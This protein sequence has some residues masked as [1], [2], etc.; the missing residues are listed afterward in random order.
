MTEISSGTGELEPDPHVECKKCGPHCLWWERS[1][2]APTGLMDLIDRQ[3]VGLTSGHWTWKS[4]IGLAAMTLIVVGF[5]IAVVTVI[6]YFLGSVAAALAGLVSVAAVINFFRRN[7]QALPSNPRP[8]AGPEDP[9]TRRHD[10]GKARAVRLS[11]FD[12]LLLD[13]PTNDLELDDLASCSGVWG[14][15]D[16]LGMPELRQRGDPDLT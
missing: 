6:G 1:R 10:R 3:M 16:G 11:R 4:M 14:Q 7:R 8:A 13:E 12:I 2:T 5:P 15:R 9:P